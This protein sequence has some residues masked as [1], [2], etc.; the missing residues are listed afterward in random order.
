MQLKDYKILYKG[1]S[2]FILSHKTMN[3][4]NNKIL[5][6]S[7]SS[8]KDDLSKK[9]SKS[10]DE[11]EYGLKISQ[12]IEIINYE[13][14][15][16]RMPGRPNYIVG[17]MNIRG[18]TIAVIDLGYR[19]NYETVLEKSKIIIV[20]IHGEKVGLI[21]QSV[22]DVITIDEAQELEDAPYKEGID[23]VIGLIK[24]NEEIKDEKS[25]RGSES[26]IVTLLDAEKIIKPEDT[27]YELI[28]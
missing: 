2:D 11:E 10:H 18:D 12:V 1:G 8:K 4:L 15:I 19:M 21:V 28:D 24:K 6:F 17:V 23:F 7:L 9:V 16:T 26:R 27:K 13:D 25:N 14:S 20:T 3:E 22:Q 5:V